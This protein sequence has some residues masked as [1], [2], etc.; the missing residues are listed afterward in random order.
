[1]AIRMA[2][3]P[4]IVTDAV[5][6][7]PAANWMTPAPRP[8]PRLIALALIVLLPEPRFSTEAP[9]GL[10]IP[11]VEKLIVVAVMLLL[12]ATLATVV[13]ASVNVPC[14]AAP[15][16]MF[17]VA[18]LIVTLFS[19]DKSS[20]A[21]FAPWATVTVPPTL[22]EP[23]PTAFSVVYTVPLALLGPTVSALLSVNVTPAGI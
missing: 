4:V 6:G 19:P 10:F 20:V 13:L 17:T 15:L 3:F 11:L 18:L 1:M 9:L 8:V 21:L 23:P 14:S 12:G 7:A 16:P 22:S 2:G 5:D